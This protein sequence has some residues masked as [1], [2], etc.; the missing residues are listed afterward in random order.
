MISNDDSFITEIT[1]L[2]AKYKLGVPT[3]RVILFPQILIK[4]QTSFASQNTVHLQC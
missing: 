2:S 3:V 1:A 4:D